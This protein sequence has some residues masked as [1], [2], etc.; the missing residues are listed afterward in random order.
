LWI[1]LGS[2]WDVPEGKKGTKRDQASAQHEEA[3]VTFH[4]RTS[5]DAG[6]SPAGKGDYSWF[7][8]RK[9]A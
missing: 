2:N 7:E 8:I 5:L 6:T 9:A 1:I 4:A 3:N